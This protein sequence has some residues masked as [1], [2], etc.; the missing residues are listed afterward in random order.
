MQLAES[1]FPREAPE[2][3]PEQIE[4]VAARQAN[5][6]GIGLE[7][8]GHDTVE[9]GLR[10]APRSRSERDLGKAGQSPSLST[11][12]RYRAR[13]NVVNRILYII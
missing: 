7:G 2:G 8:L 11:L 4:A 5:A 3:T 10:R 6:N 13:I 9:D 12:L 1:H